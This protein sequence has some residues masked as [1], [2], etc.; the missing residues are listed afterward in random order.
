VSVSDCPGLRVAGDEQ[1]A[2]ANQRLDRMPVR[3]WD[4]TLAPGQRRRDASSG[5]HEQL[6]AT[7]ER[8]SDDS[9]VDDAAKPRLRVLVAD[10]DA[11]LLSAIARPLKRAGVDVVSA[12]DGA[13]ALVAAEARVPDLLIVDYH[14]PTPGPVVV[15]ELRSRHGARPYVCVL[16]GHDDD[17]TRARCLA[18]GADEVLT[19]PVPASE[20]RRLLSTAEAILRDRDAHACEA[21]AR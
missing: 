12:N 1:P 14:M 15:R 4:A 9:Q 7:R 5:Y 2:L 11:L 21:L 18:A 10:D 19:K 17:A 8:S 13:A 6:R 3:A 16:T 20:L